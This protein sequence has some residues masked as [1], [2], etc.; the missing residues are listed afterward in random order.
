M[1]SFGPQPPLLILSHTGHQ[2]N[3]QPTCLDSFQNFSFWRWQLDLQLMPQESMVE[4]RWVPLWQIGV[5]LHAHGRGKNRGQ[6]PWRFVQMRV[7]ACS[8]TAEWSQGQPL[9]RS[10]RFYLAGSTQCWHW[11]FHSCNGFS[12]GE[13]KPPV[14][15][16]LS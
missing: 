5:K 7:D 11:G 3:P 10:F 6:V 9:A 2:F 15:S 4:Y 12:H 1:V 14:P 8:V 16:E 13:R